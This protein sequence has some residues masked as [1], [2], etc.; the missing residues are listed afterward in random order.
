MPLAVR[1]LNVSLSGVA[2]ASLVPFQ[3]VL[4]AVF[5]AVQV[6]TLLLDQVRV[7]DPPAITLIV[8]ADSDTVGVGLGVGLGVGAGAGAGA[9]VGEGVLETLGSSLLQPL[10]LKHTSTA[11][12]RILDCNMYVSTRFKVESRPHYCAESPPRSAYPGNRDEC[13]TTNFDSRP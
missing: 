7:L 13:P 1:L 10:K 9:G 6:L 4:E 11:S 5:E 8:F 3:A 12:G 2:E